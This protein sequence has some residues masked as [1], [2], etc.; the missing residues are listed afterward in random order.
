MPNN[1]Q[2]PQNQRNIIECR[3]SR[4]K[5]FSDCVGF[6][7]HRLLERR[8]TRYLANGRPRLTIFSYDYISN[9]IN[10]DGIYE[11]DL[12][13]I[14]I[15]YL[16]S[17]SPAVFDGNAVDI[18]A[19]IGN[20]SIFFSDYFKNVICF[21]A[22]PRTFDVLSLN[23]KLRNNISCHNF[24]ISRSS[25]LGTLK[26]RPTNMGSA[27]LY[28]EGA[29]TVMDVPLER[30]DAFQDGIGEVSLI[31][32]DVEGAELDVLIGGEGVIKTKMP[33]ILLE[34]A[35]T[36]INNGTSA[37]IDLLK[38]F[39]YNKFLVTENKPAI[40]FMLKGAVTALLAQL[41]TLLLGQKTVLKECNYFEPRQYNLIIAIP[42]K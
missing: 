7:L 8:A 11:R 18:G 31:K 17:F 26:I 28:D 4:Q 15:E 34:Q 13:E 6:F 40:P 36:E 14:I 12:L 33:I 25:G 20:H 22:N 27:S 9:S 38:S 35:S 37:S 5:I 10:I 29:S 19:N 1:S 32:I 16:K 42:Q 24:A 23:A 2:P 30:L 3:Y 41:Y 39:G 21:E